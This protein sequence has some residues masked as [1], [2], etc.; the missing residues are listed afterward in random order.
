PRTRPPA[1][2]SRPPA[3]PNRHTAP[4]NRAPAPAVR[5][6]APTIGFFL[7]SWKP[8]NFE[9]PS[10]N[11][12]APPVGATTTLTIDA[13][14]VI[15]RIPFSVFSHNVDFW[16][17]TMATQ[18]TFLTNLNNLNPPAPPAPGRQPRRCLFR[19]SGPRPRARRCPGLL[20]RSG[21]KK[22]S[23]PDQLW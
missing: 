10:F 8:K 20:T 15:T 17:G 19:E 4:S 11:P 2:S 13:D 5:P 9:V 6:T 12:V 3:Y 14:S 7:D 1:S 22:E 16:I 23:D 18:S 21:R